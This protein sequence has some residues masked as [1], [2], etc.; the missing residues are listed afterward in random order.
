MA[1]LKELIDGAIGNWTIQK[2]N[3]YELQFLS[4][5]YFT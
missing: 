5:D 4:K 1:K 3:V 2:M